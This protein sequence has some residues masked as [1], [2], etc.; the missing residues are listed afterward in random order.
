M[1]GKPNSPLP[2]MMATMIQNGEM[3]SESPSTRGPMMLPSTCCRIRIMTANF[4]ACSGLIISRITMLGTAPMNGPKKGSRL[5]KPITTLIS[6]AYSI[7]KNS[8]AT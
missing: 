6:S 4:S 2:T 3:P 8:I 7:F 1:P 5:V